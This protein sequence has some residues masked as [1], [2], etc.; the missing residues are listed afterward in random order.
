VCG[1]LMVSKDGG[2]EGGVSRDGGE[3]VG[4]WALL[5]CSRIDGG[6]VL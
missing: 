2:E 6:R 3:S 1:S 5:E 4:G